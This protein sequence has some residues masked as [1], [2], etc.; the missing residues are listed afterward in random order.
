M[1]IMDKFSAVEIKAD[2]RISEADKAFCQRQQDAFDKSGPA[3]QNWNSRTPCKWE[4]T[5]LTNSIPSLMDSAVTR[6]M[7][8]RR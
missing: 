7:F 4:A 3:L 8:T 5:A 6:L 2:N 1:G